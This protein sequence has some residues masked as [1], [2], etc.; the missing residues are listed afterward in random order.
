MTVS[1]TAAAAQAV[2]VPQAPPPLLGSYARLGQVFPG[3]RVHAGPPRTGHGWART[4]DFVRHP[5]A[6]GKLI[7]HDAALGLAEYGRPLRPDVAAGFCLHRYNWPVALLFTLPW[8]LERRVPRIPVERVSVRRSSGELTVQ[9]D[10]F[11]CLPDDPAA[12]LPGARVVPDEQALRDGLLAALAEHLAPVLAAFR[13]ELRRGPRTLWGMA[14]DDVVEG[15]WYIGSLLDEEA[16]AVA[17]LELLLPDDERRPPF[18][19][20]AGFRPAKRPDSPSTWMRARVS[21]CLF[22][23]VRPAEACFSCPRTCSNQN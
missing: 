6:L 22:Y 18:V 8:L 20:G 9:P 17:A 19:G 12:V 23:T 11:A 4:A 2:P 7:A 10:G 21:C 13:P 1:S 14:T 3:L 5:D 16:G 15:L